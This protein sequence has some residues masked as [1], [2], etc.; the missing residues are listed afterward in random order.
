MTAASFSLSAL[1][2][3]AVWL[4]GLSELSKNFDA[5]VH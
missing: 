5:A 1:E 3:H 2:H 4:E